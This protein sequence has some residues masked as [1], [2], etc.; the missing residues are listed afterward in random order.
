[1]KTECDE[2][3]SDVFADLGY[4]E[5]FKLI[6]IKLIIGYTSV[7]L[8]GLMYYIEKKFKNDF[9]NLNYVFYLQL[10]VGSFFSIQAIWLIFSKFV[11]KNIK[12]VGYNKENKV[13]KISTSTKNKT[14]PNYKIVVISDTDSSSQNNE[15]VIP[16]NTI[17]YS[18]GFLSI[19]DIKDKISTFLKSINNKK[20]E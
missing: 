15:L 4:T 5:S 7:V 20:T 6:D 3:L 17:F 1:M 11:E 2:H 14:D 19:V 18:D 8:A 10:L 12:Y 9:N 16:F 13:I